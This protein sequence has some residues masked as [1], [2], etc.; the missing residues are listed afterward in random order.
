MKSWFPFTDYDFYA[1]L[2]SGMLLI[3]AVDL[4]FAGSVLIDRSDWTGVQIAFWVAVAYLA[5]Q[6]IAGPSSALLEHLLSRTILHAPVAISLGLLPVRGRELIASALFAKREYA[7]LPEQVRRRVLAGAAK[8][9]GV[10]DAELSDAEAVFAVAFGVARQST[11]CASR[12]DQF[13]NVYGFARNVSFVGLVATALTAARLLE[14]AGDPRLKWACGAS[15]LLAVGMYGR[16]LKFYSGYS[17]EVWRAY[18]ATLENEK[19]AGG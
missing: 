7:P 13:R 6:L 2:T 16:F 11:D 19:E 18:L 12:L 4:T 1:Y 8:K 14:G 9:L 5:G 17:G 10:P 15:V 3:A